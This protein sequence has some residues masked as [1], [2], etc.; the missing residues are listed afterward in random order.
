MNLPKKE[1]LDSQVFPPDLKW[2]PNERF[3]SL[4]KI[5][6]FVDK[7]CGRAIQW[8]YF[9][10][11]NKR[12][13]G[14]TLR[15]GAIVA[16][17]VAGIVPI[18]GEI[19]KKENGVPYISPAWATVSLAL[20][21]LLIALDRFGGYTSGWVR[22]VRT[23]Q[24]LTILQGDFRLD[25]EEHRHSRIEENIDS[26]ITKHGLLLCKKFLQAVNSEVQTETNA[27]AQ[28]FQQA[29]M[30]VDKKSNAGSGE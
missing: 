1:D 4:E 18:V 12:R 11:I 15:A 6:E 25:W 27:W 13:F 28:E 3:V 19:F 10:K 24:R 2:S 17:A 20:A 8:Y 9:S 21:A 22:Y 7:E 29:L 5:Y 26:E 14:Y 16:V 30:E 23:A